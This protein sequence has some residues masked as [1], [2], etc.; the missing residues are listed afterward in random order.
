MRPIELDHRRFFAAAS[1]LSALFTLLLVV[2][3]APAPQAPTQ[4]LPFFR[5]HRGQ[6]F[7]LASTVL[8]WVVLSVVHTTA[9]ERLVGANR[10]ALAHAATLLSVGGILLLG[11]GTFVFAGAFFAIDAAN[12]V[13][14]NPPQANFHA[15]VWMNLSFLLSDPGLMT[16][17]AG[18]AIFG[19][20]AWIE[21]TPSRAIGVVA[22][23]GG[24]AGLLTLAVYQTPVLAV[25]Q[26]TAFCVTGIATAFVL[27]KARS[28]A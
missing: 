24:A 13:A 23:V 27:F 16:L 9:L 20:L 2:T 3:A 1:L 4:L 7:A 26:L 15:A 14:P 12:T 11:F 17:G 22:M 25:V 18:Q 5:A 28:I 10:R 6:F 8:V 19:W 21:R